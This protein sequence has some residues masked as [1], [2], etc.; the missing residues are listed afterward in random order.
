MPEIY[1]ATLGSQG[2]VIKGDELTE[3]EA[4]AHRLAGGDIVVCGPDRKANR[5]LAR[6]IE[7]A[8]GQAI[9]RHDPHDKEGPCA[10]PH[11]QQQTPP[12]LG[13]SFYETEHRKAVKRP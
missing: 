10:L 1:S 4:I 11:F 12:P 9:K 6:G 3:A 5:A 7:M 2:K 8:V 13:H